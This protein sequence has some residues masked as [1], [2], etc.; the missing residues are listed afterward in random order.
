MKKITTRILTLLVMV[1]VCTSPVLAASLPTADNTAKTEPAP[2]AV[3]SAVEEFKNLSRHERKTRV[4]DAKKLMKEY[5]ADK[6]AGRA[7][8]AD[9]V[10]LAILA[11]LLPPLAVYLKEEEITSRFWI[12][13]ILTLLFWIPGVIFALLVVFDAI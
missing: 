4:K 5:K 2:A 12:S 8:E 10:L 6:R 13:I 1:S 11:I 7:A 9:Q 3:N